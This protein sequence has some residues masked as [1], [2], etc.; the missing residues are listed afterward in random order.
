M[1][2]IDVKLIVLANTLY[3]TP[4]FSRSYLLSRNLSHKIAKKWQL[5]L[6]NK[7]AKKIQKK[8]RE[9][10]DDMNTAMVDSGSSG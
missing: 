1:G 4:F 5:K 10:F 2:T 6:V 9:I 7:A 8:K 3:I